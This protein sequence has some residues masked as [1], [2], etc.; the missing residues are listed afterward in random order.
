MEYSSIDIQKIEK[1][2]INKMGATGKFIKLHYTGDGGPNVKIQLPSIRVDKKPYTYE[3]EQNKMY[4]ILGLKE[5]ENKDS[6]VKF[7]N[8]FDNWMITLIADYSLEW[9]DTKLH[10]NDVKNMYKKTLFEKGEEVN[11][12]L[13]LPFHYGKCNCAISKEDG[14]PL[15]FE[16]VNDNDMC[17]CIIDL[18]GIWYTPKSIGVTW[19]CTKI[20]LVR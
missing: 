7:F 11:L 3:G 6:L 1:K 8:D 9:F 2:S 17:H 14:E 12:R 13:K 4:F 19:N 15:S 18:N 5:N 10:F 16:S 20:N